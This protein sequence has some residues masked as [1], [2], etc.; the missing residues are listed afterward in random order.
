MTKYSISRH[1]KGVTLNPKEYVLNGVYED[2]N[3]ALRAIKGGNII[4]A[5]NLRE[6]FELLSDEY[7]IY[8]EEL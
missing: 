7:G 1:I 4:K 8:V 2:G 5:F 6:V 3:F